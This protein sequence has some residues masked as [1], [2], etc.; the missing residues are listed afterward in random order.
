MRITTFTGKDMK[1]ID[2]LTRVEGE[3]RIWIETEKGKVKDV[4]LNIFEPPRFIEGIL[5]G[6]SYDVIPHITA[7]ICGICPVAYQMSGIQAVEDAFGVSV[8]P[9]VEALR[10]IFYYGEWI[11]SH[12][13][14]VFFLHLP[15][16]YG[17]SSIFEIAKEDRDTF[18]NALRIKNI[19]SKIIEIIGG[20]V[21]HP[22]S[23]VASGFTKY[24]EKKEL[25][26]ILPDIEKALE[27]SIYFVKKFSRF[28]FPEDDIGDI[29]FVSLYKE[30][31]YAIL[32]GD[33]ISNK[34]LK[35]TKDEF[36]EWFKEFQVP[37]STAKKSRIKGEEIYIVGAIARFNNNFEKLSENALKAA[38]D[39]NLI[40]PVK[41][42][43]KTILIR[44]IE[45]IHS[46]EKAKEEIEN[47]IKPSG[48]I[49][50][51]PKKS[52][53]TGVS[54]APRGILWH[55]Y[56]FD[57]NGLIQ[58]ADIV[59]PT[60]QNQDIMEITVKQN[61]EKSGIP[62]IEKMI[63]EA[64]KVVR[65]F[66]PCISCATHFLKVDRNLKNCKIF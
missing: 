2:I 22:V 63:E 10:K 27:Y 42:S 8:L 44:L 14:H 21:S 7:R 56:S 49:S 28:S 5:K 35:I 9:E 53:G 15:D 1:K 52:K 46:L 11:Q 41:N 32:N 38:K 6:K 34:G 24:P 64:E 16:F 57:E 50:V 65:N 36:K 25:E 33:I 48:N 54:E 55:E 12:G 20:R 60:S 62:D 61:L 47:Y 26:N 18:L 43:F 37:Y 51:K 58:T 19:G 39:I 40:P 3:G 45:I 66:D 13:I 4:V 17:K 59:P 23:V 29:H 31:E 30:D